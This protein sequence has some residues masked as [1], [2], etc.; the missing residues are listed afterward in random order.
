MSWNTLFANPTYQE[1]P[2]VKQWVKV[3]LQQ[4]AVLEG[5]V[6]AKLGEVL[7]CGHWGCVVDMIDT[8]WVLKL[9]VDP[10]EAHIWQKITDV[11]EEERYGGDGVTRVRQIFELVPG[12]PYGKMGRTRKAYGIVR[13]E[14]TPLLVNNQWSEYTKKKASN[15]HTR[16][17]LENDLTHLGEYRHQVSLYYHYTYVEKRREQAQRHLE[18]AERRADVIGEALG[19]TLAMLASNGIFLRDVHQNNIGWRVNPEIDGP[20]EYAHTGLVVFDPGHTPTEKKLLPSVSWQHFA[21]RT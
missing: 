5:V 6:G 18:Q 7:G 13:E 9:T 19:E 15:A 21:E 3:L 10:T 2:R 17:A 16:R 20:G 4:Q 11:I 12:I 1:N 14:V 8:P